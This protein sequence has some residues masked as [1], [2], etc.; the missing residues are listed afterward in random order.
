MLRPWRHGRR[1]DGRENKMRRN[2]PLLSRTLER[3]FSVV[4]F[5]RAGLLHHQPHLLFVQPPV[6]LSEVIFKFQ[7]LLA[8]SNWLGLHGFSRFVNRVEK[9]FKCGIYDIVALCFILTFSWTSLLL[10]SA[11]G[12]K[13]PSPS[14]AWRWRGEGWVCVDAS[15]SPSLSEIPPPGGILPGER[16]QV[17]HLSHSRC[18]CKWW[19]RCK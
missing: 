14:L 11:Q 12:P 10:L 17:Y 7:L 2:I 3:W 8:G 4:M 19:T 5:P 1:G 6:K 18:V 16:G 15:G 9:A 13:T